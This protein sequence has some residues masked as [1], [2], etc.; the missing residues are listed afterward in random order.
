MAQEP[1]MPAEGRNGDAANGRGSGRTKD[2]VALDLMKFLAVTTGYGKGG[3]ISAAGFSG[4][5]S[6]SAEEYADALLQ[7][8][9][10]C[11]AVLAKEPPK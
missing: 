9:E 11:R 8:F 10:R 1:A 4:K 6:R 7:L 2:E 3:A 5:A